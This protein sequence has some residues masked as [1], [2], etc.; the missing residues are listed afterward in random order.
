MIAEQ[1]FVLRLRVPERHARFL[2]AGDPVRIDGEE[3]GKS[4]PLFGAIKLVYPQIEEGR[5]VA[6]AIVDGLGDYF[7]GER[8]RVWVS[9]GERTAFIVPAHFVATRFGVDYVRVAAAAGEAIDVP[10]Q[11]GRPQPRPDMPDGVEILSGLKAGDRL[12]QP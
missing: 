9:G 4:R 8:V 12:V 7:V 11:R 1:N 2:K 5:V 6:D 10:V 3:L